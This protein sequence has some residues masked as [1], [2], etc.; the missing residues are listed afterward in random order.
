MTQRSGG[1]L[2]HWHLRLRARRAASLSVARSPT[3]AADTASPAEKRQRLLQKTPS[4]PSPGSTPG[5]LRRPRPRWKRRRRSRATTSLCLR[6]FFRTSTKRGSMFTPALR[7]L[8]FRAPSLRA[9]CRAAL[10][11]RGSRSRQ[12]MNHCMECSVRGACAL[13]A[14][15]LDRHLFDNQS[16]SFE[17]GLLAGQ[18]VSRQQ[19][20][21]DHA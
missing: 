21:L 9:P 8:E 17:D 1:D 14:K 15:D 3:R 13:G 11:T 18:F 10:P 2:L 19:R 12:Q 7:V 4:C 16:R 5:S 20:S 6:T